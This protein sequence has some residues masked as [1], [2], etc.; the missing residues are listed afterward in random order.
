MYPI[1]VV[2]FL[3]VV[4]L[5]ASYGENTSNMVVK[6]VSPNLLSLNLLYGMFIKCLSISNR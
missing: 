3:L 2:L 6:G 4:L 1:Q 5:L